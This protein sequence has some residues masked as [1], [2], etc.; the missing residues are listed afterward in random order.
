ME[1]SEILNSPPAPPVAGDASENRM[2]VTRSA[3]PS[4]ET[5]SAEV[6]ITEQQVK[7]STAAAAASRPG[8]RLVARLGR[9]LATATGD[10]HSRRQQ[11]LQRR[12]YYIERARMGR[13]MDRL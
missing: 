12:M 9:V 10:S 13:E 8:N 3:A 5:S 4:A 1:T 6:L 7:F 2:P 11:N